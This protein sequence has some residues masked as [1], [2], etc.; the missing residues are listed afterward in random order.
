ML[1]SNKYARAYQEQSK[2]YQFVAGMMLIDFAAFKPNENVLDLGSGTGELTY[3]IA[4]LIQPNGV[5]VGI[6]ADSKRAAIANN[7]K[8]KEIKNIYITIGLWGIKL[9]P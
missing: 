1:E 2:K 3:E 5:V 4:K 6:D 8:P 9:S 7:N